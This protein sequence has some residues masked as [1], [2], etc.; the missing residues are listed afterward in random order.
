MWPEACLRKL[1]TSPRTLMKVKQVSNFCLIALVREETEKISCFCKGKYLD[2]TLKN[3]YDWS[4]DKT[5]NENMDRPTIIAGN[6]KMHK[7]SSEA[8]TFVAALLPKIEN[9]PS[10]VMIA[11]AFTAIARAA[12]AAKGSSVQIGAQNMSDADEGAYTGEV[13]ARMLKEEGAEFVIL[14]HSERRSHFH[15]SDLHIHNKLKRAIS[16]KIP[17]ILCIGETDEERSSGHT[18]DV[19]TNQLL[20]ALEGLKEEDLQDLIIAYE[21]VW[22]IGT[23][24]TATPELAQEV[25]AMIRAYMK[26]NFSEKLAERL[27]ILYGGSVKPANIQSILQMPDIDGAL[28]GGASLDVESFTQ[29]VLQ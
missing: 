9:A 19:L 24:K 3:H 13:S 17:A 7:T 25:H 10:K 8:A 29:M 20:G 22:A 16:E 1:L 11:P 18:H 23:G 14:G 5:Q 4:S 12:E 26:K 21:P 28:V 2:S 15:E 6:W 27:P